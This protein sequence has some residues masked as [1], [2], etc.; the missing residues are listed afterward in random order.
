MSALRGQCRVAPSIKHHLEHFDDL[1]AEGLDFGLDQRVGARRAQ[2]LDVVGAHR[3]V[4]GDVLQPVQVVVER[5]E[6]VA[7]FGGDDGRIGLG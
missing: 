6:L 2:L 1:V 5:V 3:E 4:A 7:L